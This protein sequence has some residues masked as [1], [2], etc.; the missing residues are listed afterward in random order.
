MEWNKLL[1]KERLR[2]SNADNN[3]KNMS[4]NLDVRNEFESDFGRVVFSAA[5]RRLHDKTQV[6]PLTTDDNI[7]SRLTHSL[8]VMNIGLS[9]AIYLSESKKFM[10]KT[11]LDSVRVMREINPILKTSC[12]IHDIGNPPFGHFGEE[13][14]QDYFKKLFEELDLVLGEETPSH[15]FASELVKNLDEEQKNGLMMFL[16]D[17]NYRA[18]YCFFDGNAEGLRVLSKLQYI[19]DLYGLNLTYGT[20]ASSLKYPNVGE[21][22]KNGPIAS[23]KHGVFATEA[24]GVHKIAEA[25]GLSIGEHS[26][27]RHPLAFL[28][29]AADSICYY[30]MDIEDAIS[31]GWLSPEWV[32]EKI[33]KSERV[34]N[35]IKK[36]ITKNMRTNNGRN[37][38]SSIK[39]WV[40][41]RTTLLSYLM[42]VATNNFIK[43]LHEIESGDYDKELIED[44]DYVYEVLKTISHEEILSKKEIISLEVTGRAVITGL[45]DNLLSMLFHENK[46]VRTR[47][48]VMISKSIYKTIL[49]E[50]M[51]KNNPG[52][53]VEDISLD[54]AK[55]DPS[56]FS[57][58]ERF[59]LVRDYVACMTDKYA[60]AQFQKISGQNI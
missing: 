18:D 9:F 28:M 36:K 35:K 29:E 31:R 6:F 3:R 41:L 20:L 59:R 19:G 32:L 15:C 7:H 30:V 10:R 23:H 49:H 47:A 44:G 52:M 48:K 5:S 12:L 58:E 43:H 42:E 38:V 46:K 16:T 50:H 37:K 55:H 33:R 51:V 57:V 34:P 26:Y 21:P 14:F 22:N 4:D 25:C 54:Y 13:V 40:M 53:E 24:D 8:E 56:D 45:F 60:L 17:A 39:D 11:G 27:K 2:Q 1:N